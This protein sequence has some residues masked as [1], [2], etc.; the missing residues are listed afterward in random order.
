MDAPDLRVDLAHQGL[1]E[2]VSGGEVGGDSGAADS[3]AVT[4]VVLEGKKEVYGVRSG[5]VRRFAR[6]AAPGVVSCGG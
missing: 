5:P 6:P 4:P 2:L 3:G 1:T